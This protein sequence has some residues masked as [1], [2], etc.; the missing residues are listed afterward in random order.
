MKRQT[1]ALIVTFL[2]IAFFVAC[3]LLRSD[4]GAVELTKQEALELMNYQTKLVMAQADRDEYVRRLCMKYGVSLETHNLNF[5]T[6][7]FTPVEKINETV[8]TPASD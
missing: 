3:G 2:V 8:E 5:N 1:L 7:R 4:N 6:G